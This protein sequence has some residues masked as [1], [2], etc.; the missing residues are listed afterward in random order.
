MQM[1][2]TED[3]AEA[4]RLERM[5]HDPAVRTDPERLV[6]LLHTE[7][8][9]FGASGRRW[10][11][12]STIATLGEEGD[13]ADDAKDGEPDEVGIQVKDMTARAIA[14]AAILVTYEAERHGRRSL[15]S[16]IWVWTA[17]GWS[18]LFHQGTAIP[19]VAQ[20]STP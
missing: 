11:R 3:L 4:M 20:E 5:L 15:R 16:S 9:E 8:A 12:Q 2:D 1:P 18:V 14:P 6:A 7:F 10:D 19:G 13:Q 17:G